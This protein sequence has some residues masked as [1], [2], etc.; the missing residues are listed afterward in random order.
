MYHIFY[1]VK[2][3]D[4]KAKNGFGTLA[5]WIAPF[6]CT[7]L[8][9]INVDYGVFNYWI[10]VCENQKSVKPWQSKKDQNVCWDAAKIPVFLLDCRLWSFHQP[11]SHLLLMSLLNTVCGFC[12]YSKG[13][14]GDKNWNISSLIKHRRCRYFLTSIF[15]ASQLI[16]LALF[17]LSGLYYGVISYGII[18][19]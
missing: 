1:K 4:E 18:V 11:L 12:H 2:Q 13:T 8:F 3:T 16:Q 17:V 10:V 19:T 6:F 15:G 5:C 7:Q 14:N 9:W